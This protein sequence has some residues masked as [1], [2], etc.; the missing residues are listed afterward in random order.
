[1]FVVFAM[2]VVPGDACATARE[3]SCDALS[4][5]MMCT[6]NGACAAAS[7]IE[8]RHSRSNAATL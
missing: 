6:R 1:M 4:T 8:S 5:T 7:R 3:S 2:V